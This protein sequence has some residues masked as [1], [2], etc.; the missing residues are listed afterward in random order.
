MINLNNIR[1]ILRRIFA[2][3]K[4]VQDGRA[5]DEVGLDYGQSTISP[6]VLIAT[7]VSVTVTVPVSPRL[8]V[9]LASDLVSSNASEHSQS[10]PK[11]S[12]STN[13]PSSTSSSSS[14][15]PLSAASAD[16]EKVDLI[17]RSDQLLPVR[18]A[19]D[20]L[21]NNSGERMLNINDNMTRSEINN[22]DSNNYRSNKNNDDNNN[23]KSNSGVGGSDNKININPTCSLRAIP[24][25]NTNDLHLLIKIPAA[26][27]TDLCTDKEVEFSFNNQTDNIELI[28]EEMINELGLRFTVY[29]LTDQISK[30]IQSLDDNDNNIDIDIKSKHRI[31]GND[32]SILLNSNLNDDLNNNNNSNN[33]NIIRYITRKT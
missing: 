3:D 30:L 5:E 6:S 2:L 20:V 8:S 10:I 31:L 26:F 16:A 25:E 9:S 32:I 24:I 23:N 28:A 7:P 11:V 18:I 1:I 21:T 33:T 14:S 15:M 12:T 27:T 4:G 19:A 17:L 13:F 22:N 29:E